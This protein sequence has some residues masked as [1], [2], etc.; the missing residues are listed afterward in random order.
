MQSLIES[1]GTSKTGQPQLS[2]ARFFA[3][4]PKYFNEE[5]G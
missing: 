1:E 5:Q 3:I 2:P 4:E